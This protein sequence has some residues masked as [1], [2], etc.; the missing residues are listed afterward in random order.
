M[1]Y[2]LVAGRCEYSGVECVGVR[3]VRRKVVEGENCDFWLFEVIDD[4]K[5][6]Y[7]FCRARI[8]PLKLREVGG[9]WVSM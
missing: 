4:S 8:R 6:K 7:K 1:R 3:R 9:L 5:C 2:V